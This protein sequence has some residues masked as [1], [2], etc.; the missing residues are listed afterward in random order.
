M[1]LVSYL[2]G[3]AFNLFSITRMIKLGWKLADD[4]SKIT[5]QNGDSKIVFDIVIQTKMGMLFCTYFCR[6][7]SNNKIAN[8]ATDNT[9]PKMSIREAHDKLGHG[10]KPSTRKAAKELGIEI[11]RGAM[12]PSCDACTILRRR[13]RRMSQR[14]VTV[15]L[16][17]KVKDIFIW[18]YLRSRKQLMGQV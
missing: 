8:A 16:R 12:Q 10:D 14:K 13:N 18:I 6:G 7:H 1:T 11:T 15:W 2:P 17:P 5:L 3:G 9:V 4:K